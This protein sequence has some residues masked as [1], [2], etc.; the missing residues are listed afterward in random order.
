MIVS[1][2]VRVG[3][4]ADIPENEPFFV[5][6]DYETAAVIRVGDNFYAIED[7]CTHDD[8][9]LADGTLDG[10]ELMCPRHGATFDIRT[11]EALTAPAFQS[12]PRY[13]IKVEDGVVYVK[14]P[15]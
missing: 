3:A 2:W 1:N 12:V 6:F 8:G 10:Y 5:D 14:A 4:S 11:G 13:D 9:P 7:R 15:D